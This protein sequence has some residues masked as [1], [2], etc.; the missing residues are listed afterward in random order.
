[1]NRKMVKVISMGWFVLLVV[2]GGVLWVVV[3]V[4]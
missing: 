1:M 4:V 3:Y 2:G